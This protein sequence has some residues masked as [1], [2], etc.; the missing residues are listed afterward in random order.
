M[1][2]GLLH[3]YTLYLK[4]VFL[5]F[6][7]RPMHWECFIRNLHLLAAHSSS[8][9]NS[10]HISPEALLQLTADTRQLLS[11]KCK[12]NLQ[13]QFHAVTAGSPVSSSGQC[14]GVGRSALWLTIDLYLEDTM[15]GSQVAATSAAETLTGIINIK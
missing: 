4:H 10:K 15:D 8:L 9:R 2:V 7:F 3:G 1:P 5:C 12:T 6:L 14:H 11:R 13:Q